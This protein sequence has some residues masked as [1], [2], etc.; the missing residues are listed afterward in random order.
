MDRES[1]EGTESNH[2][3]KNSRDGLAA[4]FVLTLDN[5]ELCF[6]LI[7]GKKGEI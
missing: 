6:P 7:Q 4:L 5:L 1:F 2:M 3:L